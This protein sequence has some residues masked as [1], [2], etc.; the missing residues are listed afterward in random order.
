MS[1]QSFETITLSSV[2]AAVVLL[3]AVLLNFISRRTKIE[4]TPK[5][6]ESEKEEKAQAGSKKGK[7]SK[8]GKS[9]RVTGPV[10]THPRQI[11]ILKGHTSD[12]C[13]LDFSVNGKYMASASQG[14]TFFHLFFLIQL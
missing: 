5:E 14:L 4:Q 1:L 10:Q 2:V 8:L 7:I 13:D 6:K 3:L 9:R 12:V 11:A